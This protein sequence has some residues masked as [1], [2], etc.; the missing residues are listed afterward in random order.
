VDADDLSL[1]DAVIAEGSI[2][3]AARK[4]DLPK[5]TVSRR[6]KRLEAAAGAPLFDRAGRRLR[7]TELGRKLSVPAAQLRASLAEA[8]SLAAAARDGQSELRVASPF[9]FGRIVLS[10][11][12]ARFLAANKAVTG[13]LKFDNASIDPLRSEFDVAIR[14]ERPVEAYL[15]VAKLATARLQLYAAPAIATR[16]RS[17][18]DLGQIPAVHTANLH[19]STVSWRLTDAKHQHEVQM[20]V[21]AT[22]NDPEAACELV[23]QGVGVG[24]LPSF[25][26]RALVVE[27]RVKP[28]LPQ[29][30][31]GQVVVQA[32]LP[33]GRTSIPVVRQFLHGL[34]AELATTRFAQ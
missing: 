21:R 22:V 9:L 24:P 5:T 15:T 17:L 20:Q 26:A 23:S 11:Y 10:A 7:L 13:V 16:V 29:F 2:T 27:G 1:L 4:L 32:V 34:R 33:P 8:R 3:V 18:V 19:A 14:I 31:A 25:L 6:L 28:V 12:F 30:S